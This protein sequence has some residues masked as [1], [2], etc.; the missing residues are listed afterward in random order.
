[1]SESGIYLLR[2]PMEPIYYIGQTRNLKQRKA[3]HRWSLSKGMAAGRRI[4]QRLADACKKHG[5]DSFEF[6]VL[7]HCDAPSL[8]EREAHWIAAF[9]LDHPG[10]VANYD[11][12][13]D[14]P[15]RGKRHTESA[16]AK[17]SAS[18]TGMLKS[19]EHRAKIGAAHKGRQM[20]DLTRQKLSDAKKG[21]P[22]AALRGDANPARRP[23]ARERMRGNSNPAKR[24]EV[25]ARM[26][27]AFSAAVIDPESGAQWKSMSVCAADL[28]VSVAAVSA[29]IKK[30]RRCKGR[31]LNR[32]KEAAH[33]PA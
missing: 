26:S 30:G 19:A 10:S 12:P 3:M 13:N 17:I 21:K 4:N 24:P 16:L 6:I 23:E 22:V 9:R 2:N 18:L 28:G 31:M 29:A 15:M 11:G 5:A 1:M 20:S 14:N 27:D 8:I 33:V 32:I 7:E 25:R